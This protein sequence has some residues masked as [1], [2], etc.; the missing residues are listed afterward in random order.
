MLGMFSLLELFL[1]IFA[2]MLLDELATSRVVRHVV[3]HI[4]DYIFKDNDLV[5]LFVTLKKL[6]NFIL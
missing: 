4:V 2:K 3:F 1:D 6:K 5:A